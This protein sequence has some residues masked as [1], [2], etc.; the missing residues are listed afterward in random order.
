MTVAASVSCAQM[1]ALEPPAPTPNQGAD[2]LQ[3]TAALVE[4]DK[5]LRIAWGL[6]G[7]TIHSLAFRDACRQ[8]EHALAVTEESRLG[9]LEALRQLR[10]AALKMQVDAQVYGLCGATNHSAVRCEVKGL[11]LGHWQRLADA[12][13]AVE[14]ALKP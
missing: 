10:D 2:I 4:S 3:L 9:P 14:K 6:C 11:T 12:L 13:D 8:T 5:Q 7:S 1:P